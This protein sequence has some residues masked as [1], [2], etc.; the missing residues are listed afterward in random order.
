M[1][2]DVELRFVSAPCLPNETGQVSDPLRARNDIDR[3]SATEQRPAFLLRDASGDGDDGTL[4]SI[5]CCISDLAQSRIQLVFG[6]LADTA[7]V[8]HDQVG[9]ALIVGSL[10][11]V[12][13]EQTGET[14]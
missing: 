7:G 4:G 1:R 10:V 5:C 3:K 13:F 2:T 6:A 9:V 8:D 12:A 14:L 11:P